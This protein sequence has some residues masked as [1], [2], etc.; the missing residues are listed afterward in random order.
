M[1]LKKD[2]KNPFQ[3]GCHSI[4][5]APERIYISTAKKNGKDAQSSNRG[6]LEIAGILTEG[7]HPWSDDLS[8]VL[9]SK[10]SVI[11]NNFEQHW[12]ILNNIE[13]YWTIEYDW[14][15]SYPS[16]MAWQCFS[17]RLGFLLTSQAAAEPPMITMSGKVKSGNR[18]FQFLMVKHWH[19]EPFLKKNSYGTSPCL[20]TR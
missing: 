3:G 8:S 16:V 2:L 12:I 5:V 4:T 19:S 18:T 20:Y 15:H 10:T 17:T 13:Q 9:I 1:L 7:E 11:L 6:K 14:Y